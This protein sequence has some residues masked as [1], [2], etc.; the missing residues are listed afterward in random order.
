[1]QKAA[2]EMAHTTSSAIAEAGRR[3]ESGQNAVAAATTRAEQASRR[4]QQRADA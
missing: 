3:A 1:M 4:P 2:Q